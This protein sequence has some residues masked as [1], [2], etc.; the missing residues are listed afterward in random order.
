MIQGLLDLATRKP[1]GFIAMFCALH[2]IVIFLTSAWSLSL[3]ND[4]LENLYWGKEWQMGYYKHP[5]FFAWVSEGFVR[6]CGGYRHLAAYYLLT[7]M[8]HSAFFVCIFGVVRNFLT[9]RN[10]VLSIVFLE[11]ILF[12]NA[13]FRFNANSA[14]F[15]TYGLMIWSCYYAIIRVTWQRNWYLWIIFG[16]AAGCSMLTKYSSAIMILCCVLV[17]FG[18]KEGR[19]QLCNPFLYVGGICAA[20]VLI[21]HVLWLFAN[22]FLPFKYLDAQT[23]PHITYLAKLTAR[24]WYPARYASFQILMCLPLVIAS[25]IM[26]K[27]RR[28]WSKRLDFN[29]M[30]LVYAGVMPTVC[31]M[32]SAII[33]GIEIGRFWGMMFCG[34]LP[35]CLFYFFEISQN[36]VIPACRVVLSFFVAIM[37]LCCLGAI[38]GP[39]EPVHGIAEFVD[40]TWKQVDGRRLKYVYCAGKMDPCVSLA[41]YSK[42]DPSVLFARDGSLS[43]GHGASLSPWVTEADLMANGFVMVFN[44][45]IA[46]INDLPAKYAAL[47]RNRHY[48]LQARK[49]ET[50]YR[51]NFVR[52]FSKP[53]VYDMTFIFVK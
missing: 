8:F 2:T 33:F 43:S 49:F 18:T 11:G 28:N 1:V 23:R 32:M 16:I 20:L 21:P 14:L 9:M 51:F 45:S 36:K 15:L 13:C 26:F 31:V 7:P 39:S 10:A 27:L 53:E 42:N 30:F 44:Y 38:C 52:R 37:G 35:A 29:G 47:L 46:S 6:M 48:I 19:K 24:L 4:M 40:S 12:H 22:D 50:E 25:C 3:P 41:V 17:L 5:P 34:L